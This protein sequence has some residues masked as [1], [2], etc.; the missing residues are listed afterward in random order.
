MKIRLSPEYFCSP[1]WRSELGDGSDS[2]QI[3]PEE[4]GISAKL[5]ADLWSWA[6]EFD[7]TLNQNYPPWSQFSNPESEFKFK[8]RG[9]DLARRLQQELNGKVV[10]EYSYANETL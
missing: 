7:L 5:I 6:D 1:I 9:A 4:L 2:P 10:V 8:R 3:N